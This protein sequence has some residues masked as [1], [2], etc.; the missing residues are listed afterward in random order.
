MASFPVRIEA[1]DT[2]LAER[3]PW[4]FNIGIRV[5]WLG[6]LML[7]AGFALPPSRIRSAFMEYGAREAA[8][9]TMH[10][11]DFDMVT[12]FQAPEVEMIPAP[13]IAAVV[14]CES[15][16][17]GQDAVGRFMRDWNEAWERVS[18]IPK[19]VYDLGDDRVLVLSQV[20]ATGTTSGVAMNS[21]EE[22][23]LWEWERGRLRRLTQWWRSWDDAL[24][25]VGLE[26][27]GADS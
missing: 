20:H 26:R 11:R 5:P 22:A 12:A 14:G 13:D 24:V 10:R 9:G 18:F 15:T 7:R 4:V 6:H 8:M 19:V 27:E 17:R 2:P 16:I 3:R 23:E 21:T 25:A 1:K